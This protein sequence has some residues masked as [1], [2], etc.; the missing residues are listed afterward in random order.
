MIKLLTGQLEPDNGAV[1]KHPNARVGYIAQ[2]AFHHIEKHLTKSANEYLRWR[3]D[4][5]EDKEGLDKVT[6]IATAE[7]EELMKKPVLVDIMN[8]KSG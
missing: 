3:Y 4:N 2:H 1:W 6:M 7:E 5:G 8:E